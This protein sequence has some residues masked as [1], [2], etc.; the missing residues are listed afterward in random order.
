MAELSAL[1]KAAG[2]AS[3]EAGAS[4]RAI[5]DGHVSIEKLFRERRPLPDIDHALDAYV[6]KVQAAEQALARTRK[7]EN[8]LSAAMPR[9]ETPPEEAA[10]ALATC[11]G[12]V[13]LLETTLTTEQGHR[14][15]FAGLV[16]KLVERYGRDEKWLAMYR[17]S[18][19]DAVEAASAIA[20]SRKVLAKLA[21]ALEQ[22]RD[23]MP[24]AYEKRVNAFEKEIR[25]F[26]L[27]CVKA[28]AAVYEVDSLA[29]SGA[30]AVHPKARE[31]LEGHAAK[32]ALL[33]RTVEQGRTTATQFRAAL[34]HFQRLFA[35]MSAPH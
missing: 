24:A 16:S 26:E 27:Q 21:E 35:E 13:R 4:E 28:M 20:P 2:K 3:L 18:E 9:R 1:A 25:A 11:S 10:K 12:S 32:H 7:A 15:I 30:T 22:T 17:Q 29:K 19:R 8:A 34:A 33:V 6:K 14:R 23:F 5:R 31:V